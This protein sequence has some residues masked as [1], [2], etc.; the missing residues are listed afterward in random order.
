VDIK[1]SLYNKYKSLLILACLSFSIMSCLASHEVIP[2][3][4]I[5]SVSTHTSVIQKLTVSPS[6]SN[7]A[8]MSST[9]TLTR[10]P[11]PTWTPL[12]SFADMPEDFQA[13]IEELLATNGNCDYPCWWGLMP[14]E[15]KFA[16]AQFF[17]D[18]FAFESEKWAWISDEGASVFSVN[19]SVPKTTSE[20]GILAYTVVEDEI[21]ND[22]LKAQ[23]IFGYYETM[24]EVLLML[25]E[26]SEIQFTAPLIFPTNNVPF[27]LYLYYPAKGLLVR[28]ISEAITPDP[29]NE[30]RICDLDTPVYPKYFGA[31]YILWNP[32]DDLTFDEVMDLPLFSPEPYAPIE[33]ISNMNPHSF[34]LNFSQPNPECLEI[35]TYLYGSQSDPTK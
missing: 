11:I 28:F 10:T 33:V 35:D 17:V 34:Y 19:I 31:G 23:A 24:S 2:S 13:Q 21:R 26:P 32:Q 12:P 16:D 20:G 1:Q 3:P 25:G 5:S 22:L 27:E 15:T 30:I 4:Q 7:T 29:H 18:Q 9:T 6:L 8:I 14:G